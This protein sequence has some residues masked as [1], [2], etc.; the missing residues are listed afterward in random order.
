M[1][2]V[3]NLRRARKAQS[4][5]EADKKADA[6]RIAFGRSKAEKTLT[7]AE[8]D[9]AERRIEGHRLELTREQD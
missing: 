3:V 1:G 4:R 7:K 5:A 8:C 6:N 2:D 9:L